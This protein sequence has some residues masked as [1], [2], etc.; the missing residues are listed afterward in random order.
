[1][2]RS[3]HPILAAT[4]AKTGNPVTALARYDLER[5]THAQW[6]AKAAH[7]NGHDA[8]LGSTLSRRLLSLMLRIMSPTV[9]AKVSAK[10][11]D[12]LWGWQPPSLPGR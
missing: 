5:R 1:M 4:L 8:L 9:F 12:R 3:P 2:P 11:L 7:K 10:A 6:V